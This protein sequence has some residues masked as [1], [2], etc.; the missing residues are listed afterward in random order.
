[1]YNVP[2]LLKFIFLS[3]V[4]CTSFISLRIHRYRILL[5]KVQS[6]MSLPKYRSSILPGVLSFFSKSPDVLLHSYPTSD[7]NSMRMLSLCVPMYSLHHI[8]FWYIT[9]LLIRV[10]TKMYFSFL[11]LNVTDVGEQTFNGYRRNIAFSFI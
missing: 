10:G 2:F 4:H 5:C 1:M 11:L 9:F 3:Y 6:H 7:L 8:Y